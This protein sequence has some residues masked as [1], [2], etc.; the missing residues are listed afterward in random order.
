MALPRQSK[1][2]DDVYPIRAG[3]FRRY[4]GE[5]FWSHLFD[6]S[7]NLKN[8]RDF[9]YLVAG[10]FQSL[11]LLGRLR[12]DAVFIKG[13]FVGVPVGL[14][15]RVRHIPYFTH[16]SDTVPGLA[17]RLI[18]GGAV[19][20]AV[21]MP[22]EFYNYPKSKLRYTGIPL[23]ADYRPVD[24]TAKMRFRRQLKLP[25]DALVVAVTGGSL[26][27]MRLNKAFRA[28]A[29][30]LLR[31]LPKLHI[32]HQ[33]GMD[34]PIYTGLADS[35]ASRVTEVAY[36]EELAA[37]TGAADV[38]VAR[39]GATTIAELAVQAKACVLVPNPQLTGGQQSHNASYL[40]H[41]QAALVLSEAE[42]ADTQIFSEVLGQLLQSTDQQ[43]A[44]SKALA[45]LAKPE[46]AEALT[47]I[48]L[49]IATKNKQ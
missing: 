12:P 46:A 37:F 10:F 40:K 2:I 20:Q 5:S 31:Q 4:H 7:T 42:A 17:N 33:T 48:I 35:E 14:A 8:I 47:A 1:D 36:T 38:V 15:C 41:H 13:G 25:E 23:S 18:A 32:L 19:Y 22:E 28:V 29:P 21:G 49:D 45:D 30:T 27:A 6:I 26:G 39:A 16:D 43:K 44:L 3:K 24:E 11:G 9:F 34:V